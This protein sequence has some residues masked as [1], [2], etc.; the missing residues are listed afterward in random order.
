MLEFAQSGFWTFLPYRLVQHM[1]NLRLSPLGII[2]QRDRRPRLIVDYS[3][4]GVNDETV[5]LSPHGAMQFG[6]ALERLLFRI[7]HANPRFGPTYMAKIDLADGF[8]RLWLAARGIPNLGVVFS[9]YDDEEPL[10][11]FPLTLPIGWVESPPYF[12]TATETLANLANAVP[13]QRN[14]PPHPLE[15]LADTLPPP[16]ELP[17]TSSSTHLLGHRPLPEPVAHSSLAPF[18]APVLYHD[19]YVDDYMSLAQGTPRRCTQHRRALLHSLDD[20]FRPKDAQ[21][22]P[23]RKDVPSLKKFR[24]GDACYATCKVLLGWIIDSVLGILALPAHCYARLLAIFDELRGLRP[25][26]AR[27][28]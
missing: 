15:H 21:D 23:Q 13:T 2:P 8:Y 19:I 25:V 28:P 10:V 14:L 27:S 24:Q 7:R 9:T 16:I 4:W 18:R 11:A 3:F 20:I 22:P 17:H 6:R 5:R 26:S 12:C 1:P